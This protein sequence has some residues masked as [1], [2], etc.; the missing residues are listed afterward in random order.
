MKVTINGLPI[1]TTTGDIDIAGGRNV[2]IKTLTDKIIID[3]PALGKTRIKCQEFELE[4]E[5]IE[6]HAGKGIY[7]SSAHP[8]KLIISSH[9]TTLEA[10]YIDLA[11]RFENL[12]N[13]FLNNLK[14]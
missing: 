9:Y 1:Q 11:K 10:Q 8:N 12:E 3:A 6:I 2:E 4:G 7:L 14:K 13:L 5:Q